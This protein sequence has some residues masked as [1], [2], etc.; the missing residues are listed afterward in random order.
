MTAKT[1]PTNRNDPFSRADVF[2][3]HARQLDAFDVYLFF[4]VGC[5]VFYRTFAGR[6]YELSC[7]SPT[8]SRRCVH[9]D[10]AASDAFEW[11]KNE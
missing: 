1:R 7:D 9:D 4:S 10:V 8:V 6:L 3:L 5:G 2:R 11:R